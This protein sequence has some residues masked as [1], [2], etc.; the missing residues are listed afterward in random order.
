M[1]EGVIGPR[2]SDIHISEQ[3]NKVPA[4]GVAGHVGIPRYAHSAGIRSAG[5][6]KG[7]EWR[8]DC[9]ACHLT[10]S[11]RGFSADMAREHT[12]GQHGVSGSDEAKMDPHFKGS[13]RDGVVRWVKVEQRSQAGDGDLSYRPKALFENVATRRRHRGGFR[14]YSRRPV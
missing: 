9:S 6:R 1:D 14:H 10:T 2:R 8:R 11:H 12:R 4:R 5:Y 7:R 3:P 13:A